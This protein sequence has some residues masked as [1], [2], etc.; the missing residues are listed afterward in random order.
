VEFANA[1]DSKAAMAKDRMTLGSRYIEL[2]PSSIEELDEA[3]SRGR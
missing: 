3:V 1:E 2:F